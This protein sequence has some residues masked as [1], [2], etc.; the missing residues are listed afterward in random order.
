MFATTPSFFEIFGP[1]RGRMYGKKLKDN[2]KSTFLCLL[3]RD[4]YIGGAPGWLELSCSEDDGVLL[5]SSLLL[6]AF[7]KASASR[8]A[9]SVCSFRVQ[10]KYVCVKAT[11]KSVV[12]VERTEREIK[13]TRLAFSN[14]SFSEHQISRSRLVWVDVQ[15]FVSTQHSIQRR[16]EANGRA[17]Y[18]WCSSTARFWT[19]RTTKC[20]L[21]HSQASGTFEE[22]VDART[23]LKRVTLQP[24]MYR[25]WH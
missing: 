12:Q 13:S 22:C 19:K 16:V 4:S 7:R 24:Y 5:P 18:A 1:A 11:I 6:L 10:K 3:Y 17:L 14:A 9:S 23:K 20:N 25:V 2:Q 15:V 21:C 8:R